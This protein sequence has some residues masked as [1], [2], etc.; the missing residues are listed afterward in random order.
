MNQI[1]QTN[2]TWWLMTREWSRDM[3]KKL[4]LKFELKRFRELNSLESEG[5]K[6]WLLIWGKENNALKVVF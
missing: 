3:N 1:G 5:K 4:I 2:K 6:S